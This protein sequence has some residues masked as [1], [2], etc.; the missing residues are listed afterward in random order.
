MEPPPLVFPGSYTEGYLVVAN[1]GPQSGQPSQRF[2]EGVSVT[3]VSPVPS[4]FIVQ[5][6]IPSAQLKAIL[7]PSGE[8]TGS[9]APMR[10][11][12]NTVRRPVPSAPT[13]SMRVPS[14]A[15]L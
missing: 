2:Q 5:M 4:E 11:G 8:K 14:V 1:F 3:S 7:V 12:A 15:L 13:V 9:P 10:P 6:S